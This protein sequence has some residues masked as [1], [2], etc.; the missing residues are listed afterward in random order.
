MATTEQRRRALGIANEI[1]GR[2]ALLKAEVRACEDPEARAAAL[3][4]QVPQWALSWRVGQFLEALPKWGPA[5]VRRRVL[6]PLR[7]SESR[8][9]GA[10]SERQRAEIAAELRRRRA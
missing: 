6:R 9:L 10:L 8:P 4:A 2:R 5:A 1:R 3:L 7:I